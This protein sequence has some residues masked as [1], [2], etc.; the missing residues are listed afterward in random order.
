[1]CYTSSSLLDET[2]QYELKWHMGIFQT[3]IDFFGSLFNKQSPDSQQR[4][5][6]KKLESEL[7]KFQPELYKNGNILPNFAEAVRILYVNTKPLNDLFLD[8]IGGTDIPRRQRFESQLV[9]TGFSP[10]DQEAVHS[11][12]YEN[13]KKAILEHENA[14]ARQF[15]LQKRTLDNIV[16][17]LEGSVFKNID[18]ELIALHQLVDLCRFNFVALLQPFDAN[19]SSIDIQY[20]PL[21]QEVSLSRLGNAIEDLYFQIAGLQINSAVAQAVIALAQLKNNMPLPVAKS[22]AYLENVKKIAY[23]ITHILTADHLQTLIKI[24][25]EDA[26]YVPKTVEYK[27]SARNNFALRIQQQFH[28]DE[29]RIKTELKDMRLSNELAQLFNG[30]HLAALSGYDN[31]M[32]AKLQAST[33][34]SFAWITPLQILKTFLQQYISESITTLLNA[35]VIEGFFNNPLYKTEFSTTV[36]AATECAAK[37]QSFENLFERGNQYDTAVLEGYIRDSHKDTDF[38]AKMESMVQMINNNAQKLVHDEVNN[39][40]ELHT[41]IGELLIDVKKPNG[42]IISNLRIL[43]MSS[44][45]RDNF[46]MLEHQYPSWEIFFEIMKNYTIIKK[47]T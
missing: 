17:L 11:L 30:I 6:R 39:L 31:A 37:L 8:T 20:K 18:K 4:A 28:A 47:A 25:K 26:T 1:M 33:P 46:D 9:L 10:D 23:V 15:D 45:N 13:R 16:K 7:K 42:E 24:H 44:R 38:F 19:F 2:G 27:E 12:S 32:N 36:F 40:Q 5:Q 22:D 43:M 41:Q 14:S 21:Y 35:I 29:Q 3:I 34:L